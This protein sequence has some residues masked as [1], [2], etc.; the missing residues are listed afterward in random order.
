MTE[1]SLSQFEPMNISDNSVPVEDGLPGLDLP[2]D[3]LPDN[4]GSDSEQDLPD[5]SGGSDEEYAPHRSE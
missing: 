5:Y 1:D 2:A 3:N 4:T